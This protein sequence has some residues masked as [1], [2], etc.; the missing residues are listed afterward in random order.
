MEILG[1]GQMKV[2]WAINVQIKTQSLATTVASI[3]KICLGKCKYVAIR[4]DNVEELKEEP[5]IVY[6]CQIKIDKI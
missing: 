5:R 6:T 2:K 3:Q 1:K 4:I